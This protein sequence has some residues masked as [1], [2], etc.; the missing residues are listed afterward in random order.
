MDQQAR[1]YLKEQAKALT[2]SS[3]CC[4][5]A[6]EAARRWLEAAGTDQEA[7]R[8]G[9]LIARLEMDIMPVGQLISFAGSDA[10]AQLFGAQTAAQIEAHAKDIEAAGAVYCDCSACAAAEAILSR[11]EQLV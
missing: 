4:P 6:K 11:K 5:E 9:E 7:E 10:G 8:T 2:E 1:E 3:T